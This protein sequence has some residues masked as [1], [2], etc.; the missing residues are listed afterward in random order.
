MILLPPSSKLQC[1]GD[2]ELEMQALVVVAPFL[3]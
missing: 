3:K 2:N 1:R